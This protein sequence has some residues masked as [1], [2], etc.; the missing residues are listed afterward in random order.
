MKSI[1]RPTMAASMCDD[2][3]SDFQAQLC[4][5]LEVLTGFIFP[6]IEPSLQA[7]YPSNSR[8]EADA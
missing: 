3:N 7:K 2:I 6:I 5:L 8:T 1:T 4:F